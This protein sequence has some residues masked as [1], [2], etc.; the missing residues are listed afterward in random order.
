MTR[1]RLRAIFGADEIQQVTFRARVGAI[2]IS[3]V[4]TTQRILEDGLW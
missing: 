3:V 1:N 2:G 4:Q